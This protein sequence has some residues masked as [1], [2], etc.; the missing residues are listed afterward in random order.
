VV[1]HNGEKQKNSK[2]KEAKTGSKEI[3][4][5]KKRGGRKPRTETEK[6]PILWGGGYNKM[7]RG[8]VGNHRGKRNSANR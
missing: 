2:K 7:I 3:A 4:A 5:F 1:E 8:M 6:T